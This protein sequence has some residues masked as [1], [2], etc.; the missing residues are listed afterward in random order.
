MV[1][2]SSQSHVDSV[3]NFITAIVIDDDKDTVSV[4]SD[5]LMIKGIKVIGRGYDGLE[6]VEIYKR[7]KPDAVF[8]DVMMETYDG[9]YALEKIRE[10]HNDALVIM[11]T[12][13]LTSDTH[14]R[15]LRLNASAIIY[16]PYDINEIMHI[17]NKLYTLKVAS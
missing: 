8:L 16:K 5:F 15:L 4:L 13:D 12:A 14:D 6:A 7:L 3:D 9:L 2:T 10:I 17:L 11:V 1:K